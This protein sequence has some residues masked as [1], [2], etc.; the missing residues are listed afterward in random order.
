MKLPLDHYVLVQYVRNRRLITPAGISAWLNHDR[1]VEF[2]TALGTCALLVD[3]GYK[4]EVLE[5][6]CPS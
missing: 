2:I 1:S 6:V 5:H 4:V 3:R